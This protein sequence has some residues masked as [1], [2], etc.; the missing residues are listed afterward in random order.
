MP[1]LTDT[2]PGNEAVAASDGQ[3]GHSDAGSSILNQDGSLHSIS[4]DHIDPIYQHDSGHTRDDARES[5]ARASK[6]KGPDSLRRSQA[7][8]AC[9]KRKLRCDAKKPTCTRCEKAWLAYHSA[10][11]EASSSSSV[12]PPCEYD[13]S[14]L[15]RIF[16]RSSPEDSTHA[17]ISQQSPFVGHRDAD[18]TRDNRLTDNEQLRAQISRLQEQLRRSEAIVNS[19]STR[20]SSIAGVDPRQ[21]ATLPSQPTV[22]SSLERAGDR[23]SDG[24]SYKRSKYLHDDGDALE[25]RQGSQGPSMYDSAQ[26]LTKSRDTGSGSPW[27]QMDEKAADRQAAHR[28]SAPSSSVLS[29]RESITESVSAI[30]SR[31]APPHHGQ[32][33]SMRS[34]HGS[35]FGSAVPPVPSKQVLDRLIQVCR[36]ESWLFSAINSYALTD[37]AALLET[38]PSPEEERLVAQAL[39]LSCVATGLPLLSSTTTTGISFSSA[40]QTI[41]AL[42]RSQSHS[43]LPILDSPGWIPAVTKIYA[44]GARGLLHQVTTRSPGSLSPASFMVRL[45]LVELSQSQSTTSSSQADLALAVA[46]AR[47]L[48]L[49][50]S[51]SNAHP[52]LSSGVSQP[53]NLARALRGLMQSREETLAFWSLFVHDCFQS[54][55]AL[56]PTTLERQSIHRAFPRQKYSDAI[57][58]SQRS[59]DQAEASLGRQ[60]RVPTFHASDTSMSLLVKVSL[61]LDE[62][63]SYSVAERQWN[64]SSEAAQDSSLGGSRQDR[65]DAFRAAHESIRH[66]RV[67]LSHYDERLLLHSDASVG[68]RAG[69]GSR[70]RDGL[71]ATLMMQDKI[72]FAAE[73]THHLAVLGLFETEID[74][75]QPSAR[76]DDEV[77]SRILNAAVWLSRL[78][79]MALQDAS[80]LFS[81]P[82]VCSVGFF[83]AARWMVNL[84]LGSKDELET[85]ISTLTAVLRERGQLYSRDGEYCCLSWSLVVRDEASTTL[86]WLLCT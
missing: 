31:S 61:V 42:L 59:A 50:S 68:D 32:D 53:S 15:A 57:N 1:E 67:M 12:A 11:N 49:Y 75:M 65:D 20:E 16:K 8:L 14:I 18:V 44:N 60:R 63:Y 73:V 43:D 85:D 82:S 35:A 40:C 83:I 36:Y 58:P 64:R 81:F 46:D 24:L 69:G 3:T 52:R 6:A 48:Q 30:T 28:V 13:T 70:S 38:V 22:T 33:S 27:R 5:L 7:C 21:S 77:R 34:N 51:A 86:V 76:G 17:S 2:S 39:M 9:R 79:G 47:L 26:A 10:S 37:V 19:Q 56:L 54:R 74:I 84:Q 71:L 66:S 62:C 4:R 45:L 25:T 72:R 80:F 29:W 23:R 41:N 78:A 55:L